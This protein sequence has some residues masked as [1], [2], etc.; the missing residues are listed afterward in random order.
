MPDV[1]INNETIQVEEGITILKAAEK[2]G[3]HIPTL[4]SHKALSPYGACRVCLV[5]IKSERGSSIQTACTYPAQD[6]LVVETD[7]ERVRRDR[8]III[9]LMLARCPDSEEVKNL[10]NEYGVDKVRIKVKDKDCTLCGLCV[11]MC[12]ERMGRSAIN[13]TGRG[14][15]KEVV[16]PFGEPGDVCQVCGACVFVCPTGRIKLED[17]S[18]NKPVP[19]PAEYNAGLVARSAVYISYPQA[20]PNIATIDERYCVHLKRGDCKICSEVCEADAVDYEQKEQDL[21]IDVGAL[22][23]APGYE[24]F[25]PAEKVEYGYLK[26]PNIVTSLEFERILSASGPYKGHVLRPSDRQPP[27]KVAFIQCVGSRDSRHDYC[28]S[29][30][31]MY[32]IKE[33][34]IAKEHDPH[35][36]STIF[37]MDI[38]SYG[39]EFERYYERAKEKYGVTFKRA[40]VSDIKENGRNGSYSIL[41]ENESGKVMHEEFDLVVLSVGFQGHGRLR[42]LGNKLG[43]P[44]NRHGFIASDSYTTIQTKFPGVYICGASQEPKDIPDTVVQAS[45]AAAAVAENLS[46]CRFKEVKEKTYPPEIKFDIGVKRIGIFICHCGINIGGTVNVP[47]TV[48]YA[49]TLPDVVHVEHNLY[50]CSQDTQIHIKEMIEKYKLNR[51]IVASCT[52]RTHEPLFQETIR[53]T[54]LNRHLFSMANIRDQCSWVHM[55]M[56]LKATEK[57]KDLVRMAVSKVRLAEPLPRMLLDVTQKALVIGGGPAGMSSALSLANQGFPVDLVEKEGILGGNMNR[58]LYTLDGK[59]TKGIVRKMIKDVEEHPQITVH[60][61]AEIKEVQGFVGNYSTI[62]SAGGNNEK[63]IK[64]GVAV[65][66]TGAGESIPQEYMFGQDKRIVTGL[67]FEKLLDNTSAEELPEKLIFIQCTGSREEDHMYCSKIC[68]RETI[69]NALAF[70]R[71]KPWSLVY[72]LFRDIRSYGFSESYYRKAREAGIIFIQYDV[73][74]KPRV[75]AH[76][77]GLEVHVFDI[78][79]GSI[80]NLFDGGIRG[81]TAHEF[82]IACRLRAFAGT[83]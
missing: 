46:D 42:E 2:L 5:E 11:R 81:V 14:S 43:L 52:P 64:H 31:C 9:E 47:E 6:G 28:S 67:E 79:M 77:E 15:K 70:R 68:C 21:D 57:A 78:Q 66:A 50:T 38:R 35:I 16:S 54:G 10:A 56:P 40:R 18:K 55:G 48:E 32:A 61:K 75:S 25:S 1:T 8:K 29:V 71:K 39:K 73:S 30:C 58:V 76:K 49:K 69:K 19:I 59:E 83:G 13:F 65:I 41:Y 17:V 36:K 72:V 27:E 80:L 7:T 53:E 62:I 34:I 4:C 20:I 24:L 23:L 26:S 33:A 44:L 60:M 22:I 12:N 45:A 74:E 3:I 63:E 37:Y 51:V 82:E